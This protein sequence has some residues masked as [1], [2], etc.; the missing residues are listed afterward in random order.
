MKDIVARLRERESYHEASCCEA[1][2]MGVKGSVEYHECLAK[3]YRE[4][5]DKLEAALEKDE[6]APCANAEVLVRLRKLADAEY[7]KTTLDRNID[8]ANGLMYAVDEMASNPSVVYED[9]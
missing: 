7:H 1:D 2:G 6:T 4:C 3:M 9:S 5:A 8:W